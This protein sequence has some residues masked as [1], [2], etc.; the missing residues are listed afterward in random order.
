MTWEL[1]F[2]RAMRRSLPCGGTN[3]CDKVA[4]SAL[5]APFGVPLA[6]LGLGAFVVLSSLTLY[7]GLSG[8]RRPLD[9]ASTIASFSVCVSM[10]LT[11]WSVG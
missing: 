2:A 5:A 11:L 8:R 6:Y 1:S 3:G 10:A 9:L 7:S 4:A